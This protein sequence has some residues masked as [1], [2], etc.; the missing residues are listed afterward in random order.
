MNYGGKLAKSISK[1]TTFVVVGN[2]AGPK[3]LE[4]I[5]DLGLQTYDEDEFI[6]LLEAG[7]SGTKRAPAEDQDE[8]PAKAKKAKK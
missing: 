4:Q 2:E 6:E 7:G 3:K 8:K 1:N 5:S